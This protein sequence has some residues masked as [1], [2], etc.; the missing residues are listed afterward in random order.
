M[1]CSGPAQS[2]GS[3]GWGTSFFRKNTRHKQA[4]GR[5]IDSQPQQNLC[6]PALGDQEAAS[7]SSFSPSFTISCL[8]ISA[9]LFPLFF[10]TLAWQRISSA[11]RHQPV[12]SPVAGRQTGGWL[13]GRPPP[14]LRWRWDGSHGSHMF[15]GPFRCSGQSQLQHRAASGNAINDGAGCAA[16]GR[17]API[18]HHICLRDPAATPKP[19]G[20]AQGQQFAGSD[21]PLRQPE[22]AASSRF[23]RSQ[24]P[25][26]N[27]LPKDR[28]A[29]A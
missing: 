5:A 20:R 29:T 17:W 24:V 3:S 15:L 13:G 4:E 12:P 22:P 27:E 6:C 21:P 26:L 11:A 25:A 19:P 18:K 14:P 7:K 8:K 16:E 9:K 23:Q 10:Q 2:A 1:H 28:K